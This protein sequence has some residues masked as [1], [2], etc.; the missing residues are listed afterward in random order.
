[1][2]LG[3]EMMMKSLGV[4]PA[5]IKSQLEKV[6]VIAQEKITA[7]ES[8]LARIEANQ[9]LLYQLLARAGVI[10]TVEQYNASVAG[11]SLIEGKTNGTGKSN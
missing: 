8:Q 6:S 1:M 2:A 5:E 11:I 7:I 4:D 3:M 10:E 9:L